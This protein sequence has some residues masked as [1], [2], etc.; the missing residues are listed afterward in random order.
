MHQND[1]AGSLSDARHDLTASIARHDASSAA[2][3]YTEDARLLPPLVDF[4]R[5]REDIRAFWQA[6]VDS[7]IASL[8]FEPLECIELESVAYEIG[9]YAIAVASDTSSV[10][11]RGRYLTVHRL[12]DGRW[13]RAVEM[14]T[15]DYGPGGDRQ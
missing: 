5:G 6:G 3:T 4:V 14:Y 9:H 12:I 2:S 15:S 7:G 11:E 1:P 10:V 13:L 8:D